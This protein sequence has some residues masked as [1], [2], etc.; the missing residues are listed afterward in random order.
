MKRLI[1][2]LCLVLAMSF[3]VVAQTWHTANQSTIFWN[4]VEVPGGDVEYVV[5]VSNAI[6]DPN[7]ENPVIVTQTADV[8]HTVTLNVEGKYFFGIKALRLVGGEIVS[9]SANISW[10][11][12]PAVCVD[13]IDFGVRYFEVPADVNGIG[14]Q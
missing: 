13:G 4:A 7:K 3:T 12:N 10:S 11:D 9:E 2:A 14:I 1:L 6:T 8:M 5:Y